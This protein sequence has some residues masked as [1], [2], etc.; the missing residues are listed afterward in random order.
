M[1]AQADPVRPSSVPTPT[2]SRF[3]SWVSVENSFDQWASVAALGLGV[4][5]AMLL[6]VVI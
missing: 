5:G 1:H 4:A 2:V 6:L 3:A